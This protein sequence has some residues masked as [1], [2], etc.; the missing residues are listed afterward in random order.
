VRSDTWSAEHCH[1]VRDSRIDI[2][3]ETFVAAPPAVIRAQLD[4]EAW[5]GRVWPHVRREVVRDRG[6]KG[7]RW[8]VTGQVVGEMEVWIEPWWEGAVV[9][10]YLRGH[11][12]PD[13]P[14]DVATRHVLR[15]KQAVHGLKDRLE[16]N[17]L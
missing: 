11:R 4:D 14:R 7:V 3:D 2:V 16:G 13:A 6:V 17:S 5:T 10:H 8:T 1:V 12:Q 9:H 15:W